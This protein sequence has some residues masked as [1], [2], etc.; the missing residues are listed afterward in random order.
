[1][2][3]N[4]YIFILFFLPL[5][6]VGY[7]GLNHFKK[8]TLAQAFL[9]GMSLWF[10]G[11]FNPSYLLII[12]SSIIINYLFTL[13]MA[14]TEKPALR[15]LEVTAAVLLNLGIL[16]YFKYFDFFLM[17]LNRFAHTDFALHN[18]LLP[19]GIS[20][21]TFQQ[22]S[23]VVDA[24]RGEVSQYSFLQYASFV[25]YFPQLIAGPIVTHDELIPQ[26]MDESKKQFNWDNFARGL[27]MFVLGLAKKVLIADV[28]GVAANWGFA[29]VGLLDTT[30]AIF[31][32]LAY[33]IQIYFDFSGYCDM[34]IGIGQ[35]MNLDLPVN[36]DSPYKALTIDEFWHRW[37]KTLTRFFTKYIYIPLGGSRRGTLRTYLNVM[38]VYC[39]SG[40][41][42]GA[43]YTYI[44]WGILQ[45]VLT[46]M[47]R[48]WKEKIQK[49]HPG[50]SWLVTFLLVNFSM[51]LFRADSVSDA[52]T[53]LKRIL[54]MDFGPVNENI[55]SAFLLPEIQLLIRH[56]PQLSFLEYQP[57]LLLTAF[58]GGAMAL[59]LGAR[60]AHEHML[61]F[62]PNAK[63]A[64]CIAVLLV[65]C[66]L[67]FAGVST[68][69]YFNF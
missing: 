17:N 14:K 54:V 28:F 24:Y 38:I 62:K 22:V 42:H 47:N 13:L 45:G 21:F 48:I 69:L 53:I 4:S 52:L 36:F 49:L 9:L 1:M 27:Y 26:F 61:T 16:F 37:H 33:T 8:Y 29:N 34:A 51:T 46:V 3:F 60:N 19:L 23:Y 59:I 12:L 31:S 6:L 11:Y 66:V 10:Y 43:N 5:C 63:N 30:N 44:A 40:L 7:F 67:S 55:V 58:Y 15:K 65:W 50:F 68:F 2:L 56:V 41:W 39:A 35:M 18:I 25:A 64:L 32:S 57:G 20:F